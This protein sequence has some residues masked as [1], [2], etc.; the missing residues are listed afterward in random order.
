VKLYFEGR[1]MLPFS[2]HRLRELGL[3]FDLEP[4]DTKAQKTAPRRELHGH[5]SE[6]IRPNPA[7]R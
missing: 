5:Q 6:E 7:A 4:V 1:R 3:P 2:S